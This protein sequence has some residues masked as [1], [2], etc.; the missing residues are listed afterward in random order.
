MSEL[1]AGAASLAPESASEPVAPRRAAAPRGMRAAIALGLF[2]VY[3]AFSLLRHRRMQSTG[4]DLGIFDQ[5]VQA[6]A[7]FH[8]P[9]V[10]LKGPGTNLLGDHFHPIL[11]VLAPLY[12]LWWDPRTLLLAQAALIAASSL[13]LARLATARLGA[14]AGIAVT[15]A[16]GLSWGIQG[17]VSFDFHEIAFAVPL[18]AFALVALAEGRWRAGVAWTL[19]LLLVKEDMG[20]VVGAVGLFLL[21]KKQYRLGAVTAFAGPAALLLSITVIIPH[22]NAS[23][24]YGYWNQMSSHGSTLQPCGARASCTTT[25]P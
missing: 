10:P 22:F 13:P 1:T 6:Y 16:Y 18:L 9:I 3:A 21:L 15:L 14:R 8:A 7:R 19:P 24:Q 4:Y 23:G 12:W 17:A 11:V 2:A 25:P 20:L 5:A